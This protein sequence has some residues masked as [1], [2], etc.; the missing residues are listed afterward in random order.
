MPKFEL[1]MTTNYARDWD[2]RDGLRELIQN[3]LDGHDD[4][5]PM[6]LS[7]KMVDGV[8]YL[9]L[10]NQG[11]VLDKS[12]WLLGKSDKG[13]E[14]RGRHGDGLKVGTLVLV[15]EG[16]KVWFLNGSEKWT[17]GIEAS[18]TFSGED[19]LTIQTR[20]GSARQSDFTVY[21]GITQETWETVRNRYLPFSDVDVDSIVK[22]GPRG[23]LI[24]DPR[25]AGKVF[26][27]G[28]WVC[29]KP[30]SCGID[31]HE[32]KLDRDRR[33]LD[34]WDVQYEVGAIMARLASQ[35]DARMDHLFDLLLLGAGDVENLYTNDEAI[36]EGI[37]VRFALRFGDKAVAVESAAEAT[38]VEHYGL[39]GV[40][41]PYS[42]RR[43]M[44]H[45]RG[46]VEEV[47]ANAIEACGTYVQ[48]GTLT[49]NQRI[50][51]NLARNLIVLAGI[52]MDVAKVRIF[53]FG[54]APDA[55]RG[56]Y[57]PATQE[58]R[59]NPMVLDSGPGC[60]VTLAHELAHNVGR[61]GTLDHRAYE[62]KILAQVIGTLISMVPDL[63]W[64]QA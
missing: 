16:V 37:A 21:V 48:D 59:I 39:V 7:F 25:Y 55:P 57:N 9:C 49:S 38:K 31:L 54:G 8:E 5:Y 61:D 22:G 44:Q 4:G 50:Q 36:R 29:D 56:T 35:D 13:T 14:A 63:A 17:P 40:V 64:L 41:V 51:W 15:R 2:W 33:V 6:D 26:V 42:L 62:E 52:V 20:A 47:V 18:E 27:K 60:V 30:F 11:K 43:I 1:T 34:T 32:V 46:D 58:I 53:D 45:A 10:V 12:A 3:M 23:D 28:I 24:D 19:V